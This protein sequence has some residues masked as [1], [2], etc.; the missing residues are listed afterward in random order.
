ML[1]KIP[2]KIQILLQMQMQMHM[3]MQMQMQIIQKMVISQQDQWRIGRGSAGQGRPHF[4]QPPEWRFE[5]FFQ[6]EQ[7]C[8]EK[9]NKNSMSKRW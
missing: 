8:S 6:I 1:I 2:M 9:D 7:Q 3:H 5:V 4:Q